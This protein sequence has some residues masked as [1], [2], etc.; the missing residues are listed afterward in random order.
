MTLDITIGKVFIN[1]TDNKPYA[2]VIMCPAE[3]E[4]VC[5]NKM[6]W[7]PKESYRSGSTGLWEFCDNQL[8]DI[9][10]KMCDYPRS[11]DRDVAF[12]KPFIEQINNL[13]NCDN[14]LDFDRMKWFKFWCNKSVEL[15]GDEAAIKFT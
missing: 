14:K 7:W 2:D 1:S 3:S 5:D 8:S 13:S 10:T 6:T 15:Y 4:D 11:N 9:Y 12:I